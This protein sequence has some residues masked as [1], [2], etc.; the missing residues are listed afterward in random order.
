[1]KFKIIAVADE[2]RDLAGEIINHC[3]QLHEQCNGCL[4][5][6]EQRLNSFI[7]DKAMENGFIVDIR[8]NYILAGSDL[9]MLV[10]AQA[11]MMEET[12]P[13]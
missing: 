5:T 10:H 2:S 4:D 7:L 13:L 12:T 11:K 9:G 6:I 8:G 1:M 3:Q